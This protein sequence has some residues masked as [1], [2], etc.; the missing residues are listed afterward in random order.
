[1]DSTYSRSDDFNTSS[2]TH[3]AWDDGTLEYL[4]AGVRWC[5]KDVYI[6]EGA[7]G[8]KVGCY[9]HTDCM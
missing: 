6:A 1:M 9:L 4:N 5:W 7:Q 2:F 3:T 8:G